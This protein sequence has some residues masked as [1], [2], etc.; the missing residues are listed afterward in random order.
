MASAP[1]RPPA[2]DR[3]PTPN[4]PA[5]GA[6][7]HLSV[8]VPAHNEAQY[9]RP[10]VESLVDGLRSRGLDFEV[11]VV[12][13]GSLDDTWQVASSVAQARTEVRVLSLRQANY[14][15]ALRSGFRA[16]RGVL[17]ANMDVDLVDLDFLDAAL[18]RADD[19]PAVDVVIGTKR[20]A[21]AQ[22]RR[23]PARRAVT[24]TFSLLMQFGFGLQV[25][26]TH[27]L[28]LL[29]A[30]RLRLLVDECALSG[31]LFDTEL[32][33]RAERAGMRLVEIP[34][35]VEEQRP[36]RTPIASRVPR[37]VAGLVRLRARLGPAPAAPAR[38]ALPAASSPPPASSSFS[39]AAPPPPPLISPSPAPATPLPPTAPPLSS[40]LG[41]LAFTGMEPG[42]ATD[43]AR[44]GE[45]DEARRAGIERL[46]VTLEEFTHRL[47]PLDDLAQR[48]DELTRGVQL[49]DALPEQV[50]GLT[51]GLAVLGELPDRLAA[52]DELPARLAALD[53]LVTRLGSLDEVGARLDR[54]ADTPALLESLGSRTGRVEAALMA[55]EQ[56]LA[57]AVD[58]VGDVAGRVGGVGDRVAALGEQLTRASDR[59][60]SLADGAD[61]LALAQDEQHGALTAL[62]EEVRTLRRRIPLRGRPEPALDDTTISALADAVAAR[63]GSP[64]RRER[65]EEK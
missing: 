23:A 50:E 7:P 41:G 47:A 44:K 6:R 57:A 13:N 40:G 33:L 31:D 34:V 43:G 54:L 12:E 65:S 63:L 52:L 22:D 9:L 45:T 29:R 19:D 4:G 11:V 2:W 49:L 58:G 48:V 3:P 27:G 46:V 28:K 30:D 24:G 5:V 55:V 15:A 36:P 42:T 38:K 35:T 17:V 26:D 51:A 14:G 37:T 1:D 16:A 39:P 60:A 20:G 8:V 21:G 53:G 61:R 18:A 25:S 59:L 62:R 56:R 10:A 32:V 64:A